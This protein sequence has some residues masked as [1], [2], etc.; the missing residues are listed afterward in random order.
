MT[1]NSCSDMSIMVQTK[2]KIKGV[3]GCPVVLS[4][5]VCVRES[6]S[7]YCP[8]PPCGEDPSL[9][10]CFTFISSTNKPEE[11][12]SKKRKKQ[13]CKCQIFF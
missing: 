9:R 1:R 8:S 13:K 3:T 11:F 4:V 10:G 5:C 2:R 7:V 12:L 6:V